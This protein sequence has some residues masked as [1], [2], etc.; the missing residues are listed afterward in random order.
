LYCS[1]CYF[2]S[3]PTRRSSDLLFSL[4]LSAC[5][6]TPATSTRSLEDESSQ[7]STVRIMT[8]NIR[9]NT[10]ADGENAWPERKD[11]VAGLIRFH[12][13]DLLGV[14]EAM[15]IQLDD[16]E[17]RLPEYGWTGV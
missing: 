14:Q 3:F 16:L 13:P 4:V 15:K 9:L 12:A 17:A 10:P 5:A 8:Y 2:S 1:R 7:T 6:G 11:R